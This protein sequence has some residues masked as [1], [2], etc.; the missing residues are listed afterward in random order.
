MRDSFGNI[1]GV[2]FDEF[3]QANYIW[4]LTLAV[5]L[6]LSSTVI[7]IVANRRFRKK[8]ARSNSGTSF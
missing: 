7:S 2:Q 8:T 3:I 5:G 1:F 6:M 4:L